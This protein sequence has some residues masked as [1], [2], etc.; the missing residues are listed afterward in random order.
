MNLKDFRVI[1]K[2]LC[3][4]Y[5]TTFYFLQSFAQSPG[6]T[7]QSLQKA[8]SLIKEYK[9]DSAEAILKELT[10]EDMQARHP[11]I[12]IR[13]E[14]NLGRL[15]GDRG[16]NVIALQHYQNAM[17]KAEGIDDKESVPFILKNMGVLYVQW[18]KF[19]E[20]FRY[21][22]KAE[23]LATQ[24]GNSEL[25]ADCQNNKGIVYEQRNDYDKAL[26]AYKNALTLY[27]QKK[28]PGKIAMALSNIAIIYKF[29]KNYEEAI[30]YNLK[31]IAI[32]EQ[33]NDK[34]SIAATYNN[35][36]NLYGEMGQYENAIKYCEKALVIAKEIDALE[37]VESIYDSMADAAVKANDYKNAYAYRK[38][39]SE[40]MDKFLN[41]ENTRQLSELNIKYE[42]EKKQI[43]IQQQE[44]EISKKNYWLLVGSIA[45]VFL[46][47]VAWFIYR[48][49]KYRQD[50]K[51]QA[52]IFRQQDLTAKALFE[53]EQNERIRIARDLHDGVGQM[54]SLVKM[55]LSTL[56]A[57]DSAVQKAIALTDKTINEVRNVSHNLLPE[58]LNFGIVR[59]LENLAEKVNA[60]G[61]TKM[62]I[63]IP[64]QIQSVQF[65]KQNELS[66]YRIVQEVVNNMIKHA[67]ANEINLFLQPKEDQVLISI[68]DNGQG[69]DLSG[70][71]KWKGIGWKNIN[72]RVNMLDGKINVQS[73]KL[74]GTQI[75]ITIPTDGAN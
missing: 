8:I 35:I 37:I 56:N 64:E 6:S 31:A 3:L 17:K 16:N 40:T 24:S 1:K 63:T 75:E 19:D 9:T 62:S 47:I 66:I 22:D 43:L 45:F 26:A 5:C 44:F 13:A 39:Y 70:K 14:L 69:F 28:I 12:Y 48:N 15:Y 33:Q 7:E 10:T 25:V 72:A 60:S 2:L 54:L 67:D 41:K 61:T 68:K 21:Y 57:S 34:W 11:K 30:Q 58:E 71:D 38:Q 36:G 23:N 51:L 27:T 49:N 18:K 74:S 20:A 55:N 42:T 46:G 32:E 52:E 53:T 73:E 4:L 50:E 59:A 29:Q 65:E